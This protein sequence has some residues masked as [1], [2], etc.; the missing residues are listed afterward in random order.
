VTIVRQA[1]HPPE[2]TGEAHTLLSN[3]GTES[4]YSVRGDLGH[5]ERDGA[6]ARSIRM[7]NRRHRAPASTRGVAL[8]LDAPRHLSTHAVR[9]RVF[10]LE[11]SVDDSDHNP[12]LLTASA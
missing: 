4:Q 11:P 2:A 5:D 9:G 3:S 10:V 1:P 8:A 7:A 12:P 6:V